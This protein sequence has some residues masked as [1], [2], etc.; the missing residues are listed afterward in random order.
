[1]IGYPEPLVPPG[2]IA[3][4]PRRVRGLLADRWVFDSR[5]A[6]YVW[7]F[8]PYP[9]YYIPLADLDPSLLV[10]DR[11]SL[12][13]PRG[14]A[15]LHSLR[16]GDIV[17]S[18]VVQVLGDDASPPLRQLARIAWSALDGWY[19]EDEPVFVHPRNPYARVDALRSSRTV[20]IEL[21]GVV[22]ADAPS[23]VTVFETG[24]PPRHYVE[25]TA[26]RL[27]HLVAS[28]TVTSCPYKGTTG[29]YWSAQIAERSYPDV[30]WSYAFTTSALLPAA[31]LVAFYGEFGRHVPGR[32]AAGASRHAVSAE[33]ASARCG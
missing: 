11:Q 15:A 2:G 9:Q 29:Q 12:A 14:T 10:N 26:L 4:V 23:C 22:L 30:A 6:S 20:R 28:T 32:R 1:M 13:T 21:E 31:G 3:P 33:I 24:L 18:G 27:E 17:R 25:R 19:E 8:P 7:E 5:R 16:V